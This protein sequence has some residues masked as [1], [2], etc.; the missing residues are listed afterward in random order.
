[1]LAL[2]GNTVSRRLVCGPETDAETS[3]THHH[4]IITRPLIGLVKILNHGI[5]RYGVN[6][7]RTVSSC[8]VRGMNVSVDKPCP[9]RSELPQCFRQLTPNQTKAGTSRGKSTYNSYYVRTIYLNTKL[10]MGILGLAPV[11]NK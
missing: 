1:M 9:P 10:E 4:F 2:H 7:K 3:V 8:Y 6:K 5:R 11:D